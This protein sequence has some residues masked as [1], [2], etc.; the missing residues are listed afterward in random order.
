MFLGYDIQKRCQLF[1]GIVCLILNLKL[2]LGSKFR[3]SQSFI[4]R[5]SKIENQKLLHQRTDAKLI[6][7]S[8]AACGDR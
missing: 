3:V 7:V 6:G 8:P 4:I 1:H 2:K 5:H